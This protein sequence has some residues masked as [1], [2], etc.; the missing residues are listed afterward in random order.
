MN[1]TKLLVEAGLCKSINIA[2]G[3]YSR[4]RYIRDDDGTIET[5]LHIDVTD[6]DKEFEQVLVEFISTYAETRKNNK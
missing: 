4:R 5:T 2:S 1:F 3:S 6:L